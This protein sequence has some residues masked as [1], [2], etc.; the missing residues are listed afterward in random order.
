MKLGIKIICGALALVGCGANTA[1]DRAAA[2]AAPLPV[3][4][5]ATDYGKGVSALAVGVMHGTLIAAGGANFPD[6]P[7]AEGGKKR[8]YDDIYILAEGASQW[9]QAGRLPQPAAYGAVFAFDGRLIVAGG[10]NEAGPLADVVEIVLSSEPA[11]AADAAVAHT[12]PMPPLPQ[13]TEQAAAARYGQKLYI[14]G[15]LSNGGP[16]LAIFAFDLDEPQ[17]GWRQIAE[18]PEP[19]VQPVA[20]ATERYL[21]VW[22]G[23]DPLKKS[24]ADY[25][26]RYDLASGEAVPTA[27]IP[28]RGT[29]VGATVVQAP[30]GVAWLTGGVNRE[31]F[32]NALNLPSDKSAEYLSQPVEYYRFRREIFRFDPAT[33]EWSSA[34][35]CDKTARAGAGVVTADGSLIIINGEEKPGIRSAD[36]TIVT[37]DLK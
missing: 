32:N 33:E 1:A 27:P 14:A 11:E 12:L 2:E 7:A 35:C 20:A 23:F 4:A 18:L 36:C 6:T 9:V 13:P 5:P 16:S 10:A 3:I 15:G 24:A 8:F 25:G 28:D 26:L 29:A 37:T 30:D 19:S 31:I 17:N 22:G 34:G 21:Y